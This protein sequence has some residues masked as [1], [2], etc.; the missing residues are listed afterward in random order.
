[1]AALDTPI[2]DELRPN[3]ISPQSAER[4][5]QVDAAKPVHAGTFA[6]GAALQ[7]VKFA[8]PATGRYFASRSLNAHDGKPTPPSRNLRCWMPTASRSAPRAGPSPYVDSEETEK[9]DGS[10]GNAIDGQTANFWHTQWGSASP[11][12]PH[13]LVIDLGKPETI[14]GFRYTPRQGTGG[15]GRIKEFRALVGSQLKPR[16]IG[17]P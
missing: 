7:E 1:M 17:K 2:L 3:W 9:E 12:H 11:D 15:G 10:A 8:A 14:G 16:V 4:K 6:P 5:L 13:L